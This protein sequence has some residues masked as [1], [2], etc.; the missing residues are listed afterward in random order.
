VEVAA[1]R[2]LKQS[3]KAT[4]PLAK[5]ATHILAGE[6]SSKVGVIASG[7]KGAASTKKTAVPIHKHR[8]P[9]IGA[10]AEASLEE[11]QESSPSSQA[12]RDSA[13]RGQSPRVSVP[14]L[15]PR[16]EPKA[17]LQITV[18]LCWDK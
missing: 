10:M 11:S 17:L 5:D 12:A 18:P 15:V 13:P 8:V 1:A 4:A 16:L 9:T 14:D 3:K 7:S 2:P 6:P